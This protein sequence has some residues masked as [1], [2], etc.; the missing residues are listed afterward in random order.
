MYSHRGVI[1]KFEYATMTNYVLT[2]MK[3]VKFMLKDNWSGNEVVFENFL[4]NFLQTY[5]N[6]WKSH[7]Y[8]F[9]Y[10]GYAIATMPGNFI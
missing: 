10:N 5:A 6:Y 8:R 3:K 1:A 2:W 7:S 9:E 4:K